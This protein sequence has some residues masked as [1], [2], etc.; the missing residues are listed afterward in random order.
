MLHEQATSVAFKPPDLPGIT[1]AGTRRIRRRR[2]VTTLS[3]VGTVLAVAI[4]GAGIA[5]LR[6]KPAPVPVRPIPMA[7]WPLDAVTWADGSTIHVGATQTIDVGHTVV[8][9]VRTVT[10]FVVL[11]ETDAVY[12]ITANGV[13]PIGQ[14]YDTVPDNS[15]WQLL[16]VDSSGMLVGWVDELATP[17]GLAVRIYDPIDGTTQDYPFPST[18]PDAHTLPGVELQAID[19]GTA[20]WRTYEGVH[21]VDLDSGADVLIV[22]RAN[23]SPPDRIY[24]YQIYSAENGVLAF[25]DDDAGDLV[26]RVGQSIEDAVVLYDFGTATTDL[27]EPQGDQEVIIGHIDPVRLSPNGTW[28]SFGQAEALATPVGDPQ[29]GGAE[30]S[31]WR[32]APIVLD[33]A[34]GQRIPLDVPGHPAFAITSVWLDTDTVQVLWF[35]AP[36]PTLAEPTIARLYECTLPAGTCVVATEFEQ[37]IPARI[38][39]PDGRWYD[40]SE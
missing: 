38:A 23:V 37:P 14:A 4:A 24:S 40:Q 6:E 10:G 22:D 19:D 33:T 21:Q 25:I 12:S 15:D 31:E 29:E 16:A 34:T 11:D 32:V 8:A 36:L 18:T 30:F 28:L 39:L 3:V 9:Y 26:F 7:P 1:R 13:D 2:A 27:P 35:E 17:D 5:S 20:Y